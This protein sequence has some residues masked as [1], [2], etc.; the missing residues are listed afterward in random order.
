MSIEYKTIQKISGPLIFVEGVSGVGYNELVEIR[1]PEGNLRRGRVLEINR[2]IAVVE[3]FEGT[4]GLSITSSTVRFLGKPLTIPLSTEM[5]GRIFNGLGEPIDG[6]P[7]PFTEEYRDV[8]GLPMNPYARDYPTKFI[9][10]GVSAIDGMNTLVRGQKLPIFSGSGLPHNLLATQIARQATIVGE[11]EGFAVIFVAMGIK[12]DEAEFFKKSFEESGVL[13]NSALFLNLA[14]DPPVERLVTPRCAL[15]LAEYLA[16]EQDMH[17]LVILTDMTNYAEALREISAAREEVPSR[18]G[19]PGYMYSDLASI[20]ERAGRI[21]GKKGSI[22]QMPVLTM[23]NDDITHPIPDLT[24]YIT[25]GQ[26]VLDR[27]LHRRGIY[28]PINVLPSL[29]RLMKDGIGKGKTR[30]DHGP[31]SNQ[32]YAAY[33]RAQELRMLS[34]II[35]EEGLTD[36]DKLYLKFGELFERKFLSQGINE[37]RTLETTLNIAWELLSIFPESELTRIP[38]HILKKYYKRI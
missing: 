34:T 35:G 18:K 13:K 37:N 33:A 7:P 21:K 26:I 22:T 27:D 4:T 32:L 11:E 8:N 15:T 31:V 25:E 17:I 16:F 5:L 12:H 1:D 20:Y 2:N 28:P 9:Q 3:V 36:R 6:G 23:P 24:G 30:E 19:Y 10:T 14:D 29:S 38:D